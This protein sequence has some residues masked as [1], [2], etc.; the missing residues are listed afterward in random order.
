[1]ERLGMGEWNPL[2][3]MK[4]RNKGGFKIHLGG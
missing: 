2:E 1:M 3:I 4:N